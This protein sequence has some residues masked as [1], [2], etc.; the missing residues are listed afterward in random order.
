MTTPPPPTL[1]D[2]QA[3]RAALNEEIDRL[4]ALDPAHHRD[5]ADDI[6][7]AREQLDHVDDG[8]VGVCHTCHGFIGIERTVALPG[9][10]AC[11]SCASRRQNL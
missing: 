3:L 9:A 1:H 7:A 8:T 10:T 2:R 6:A 4:S 5:V 11:M